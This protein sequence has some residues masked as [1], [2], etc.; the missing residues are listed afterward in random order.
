MAI[1]DMEKA[2][3]RSWKL[4]ETDIKRN[5]KNIHTISSEYPN[6]KRSWSP[7]PTYSTL[8]FRSIRYNKFYNPLKMR[9]CFVIST[10]RGTIQC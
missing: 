10:N 5:Y 9:E 2:I 6:P 4:L 1:D 7:V 8:G 3:P